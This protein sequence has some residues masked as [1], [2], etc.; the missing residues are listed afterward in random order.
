MNHLGKK[1]LL[2]LTKYSRNTYPLEAAYGLFTN[3][4]TY[5][6]HSPRCLFASLY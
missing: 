4:S 2:I 3:H 5:Q 1:L 6:S